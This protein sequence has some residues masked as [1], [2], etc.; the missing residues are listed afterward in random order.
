MEVE[1][2]GHK[3]GGRAGLHVIHRVMNHPGCLGL[4]GFPGCG[5]FDAE[6]GMV[7][8]ETKLLVNLSRPSLDLAADSFRVH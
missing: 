7:F 3:A 6:V 5:T 1:L 8:S 2:Q 4:R